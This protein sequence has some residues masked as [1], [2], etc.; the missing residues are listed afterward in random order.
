MIRQAAAVTLLRLLS[1]FLRQS[2][3]GRHFH[4]AFADAM[5][6]MAQRVPRRAVRAAAIA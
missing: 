4:Y 1:C 6:L 2:A 5:P 3:D